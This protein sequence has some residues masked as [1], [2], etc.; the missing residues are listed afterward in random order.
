[1]EDWHSYVGILSII[2]WCRRRCSI[3]NADALLSLPEGGWS[4]Y[5]VGQLRNHVIHG[6]L[7][8]INLGEI[9]INEVTIELFD[10][11]LPGLKDNGLATAVD[12]VAVEAWDDFYFSRSFS[13]HRV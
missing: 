6:V 3:P 9:R 12:D 5:V 2:H 13:W 8:V 10:K 11:L 4:Q 1:M 7:D